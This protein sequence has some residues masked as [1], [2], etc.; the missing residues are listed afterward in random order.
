MLSPVDR[1]VVHERAGQLAIAGYLEK[2]IMQREL[3]RVIAQ[4]LGI[5]ARGASVSVSGE[6]VLPEKAARSLR[7]LLAEDNPA[8]QKVAIYVLCQ[9]G[10]SVEIGQNGLQALEMVSQ[11]DFDVVLMDVQMPDLDGLEATRMIRAREGQ[12]KRTPIIAM[13]AHA[14]KGDREQCLAAG[15][16]GYLSKPINDQELIALVES[17]AAASPAPTVPARPGRRG[18]HHHQD[19][20]QVL[21]CPPSQHQEDVETPMTKA[22]AAAIVILSGCKNTPPGNSP[23]T[24]PRPRYWP[25][26]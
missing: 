6:H 5:G 3:L 10:H 22:G 16:D 18:S 17:L 26:F 12:G 11:K 4:G 19:Q 1:Q 25:T 14:M 13:T 8:N 23:T 2:P 24:P 20:R 21:P 15:M 9:R 7:I